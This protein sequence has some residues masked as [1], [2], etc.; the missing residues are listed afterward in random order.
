VIDP[1]GG[2]LEVYFR[3]FI[4]IDELLRVSIDQ[5]KLGTLHLNHYPVAAHKRMIDVRHREFDLSDLIRSHG[6][7]LQLRAL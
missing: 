5:G 4:N 6:S 7:S 2:F 1:L 3:R